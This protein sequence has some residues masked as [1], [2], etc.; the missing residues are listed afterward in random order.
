MITIASR[1]NAENNLRR[2]ASARR[3][4][5]DAKVLTA[6]QF[7]LMVALPIIGSVIV[8]VYPGMKS[9]VAA[10]AILA[11]LV[12]VAL[13]ERSQKKLLRKGA[14]L[15][16]AFDCDVLEIEW[17][18]FFV[19]RKVEEE[20]V[21]KN[22]RRYSSHA[23]KNKNAPLRDW[24]PLAASSLPIH[25][26]RIICQRANLWYDCELRRRVGIWALGLSLFL[27]AL[28]FV[29]GAAVHMS[30]EDWVLRVLAP[31]MPIVAWGLK[32]HY[33]Q[34]D[35]AAALK[36]LF[37]AADDLWAEAKKKKNTAAEIAKFALRSRE[38]QTAIFLRRS[39][40]PPIFDWIYRMLRASLEENMNE[41]AEEMVSQ[42]ANAND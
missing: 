31:A 1:Q 33:K 3:V 41:S 35:A 7:F 8:V 23:Q 42:V 34:Q 38:F 15:Q 12:D 18:P 22:S 2:Q 9:S 36:Q 37:E 29:F 20:E 28:F 19:G 4:Y 11:M 32:E 13:L 16:E 5:S 17:N 10:A 27:L 40:S 25:L 6:I 14:L 39:T 30:M 24:Y 21:Y 26:G